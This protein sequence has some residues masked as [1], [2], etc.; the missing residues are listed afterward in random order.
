MESIL[1]KLCVC[2]CVCFFFFFF[3]LE[4]FKISTVL[5]YINLVPHTNNMLFSSPMVAL[6]CGVTLPQGSNYQR[7]H[8]FQLNFFFSAMPTQRQF[9]APC[10]IFSANFQHHSPPDFSK[11]PFIILIKWEIMINFM[12]I[13]IPPRI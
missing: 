13:K 2:V 10:L 5:E 3:V 6:L 7:Q 12:E 1:K 9:S 8:N 4:N 11:F